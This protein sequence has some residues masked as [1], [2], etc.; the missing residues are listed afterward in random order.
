MK[1]L[2]Y[3]LIICPVLIIFAAVKALYEIRKID[4]EHDAISNKYKDYKL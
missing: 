3:I 1:I 4:K 2:T